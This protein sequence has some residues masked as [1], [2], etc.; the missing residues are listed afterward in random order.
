MDSGEWS[1]ARLRS[2]A[3]ELTERGSIPGADPA[4]DSTEL[5]P[6]PWGWLSPGAE[7]SDRVSLETLLSWVHRG[8]ITGD[9]MVRG[10]TT[11]GRWTFASHT[12]GVSKHLRQCPH[13]QAQVEPTQEICLA[14]GRFIDWPAYMIVSDPLAETDPDREVPLQRKWING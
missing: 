8:S 12:P 7:A 9:S 6:G 5:S 4:A 13:C 11:G 14:C 2:I 1:P 10:P 3:S